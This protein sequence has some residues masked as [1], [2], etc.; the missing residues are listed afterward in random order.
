MPGIANIPILGDLF[1][2]KNLNHSVVELLV[3]VTASVVDPL[4]KPDAIREPKPVVPFLDKSRFDKAVNPKGVEPLSREA[5][6]R[7]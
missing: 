5:G 3:V 6:D 2:S 4:T 1:R 7:P